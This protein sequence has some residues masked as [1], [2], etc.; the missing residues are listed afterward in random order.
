MGMNLTAFGDGITPETVLNSFIGEV[1][2]W[3]GVL[4]FVEAEGPPGAGM[5]GNHGGHD[6]G[7]DD[8]SSGT[9]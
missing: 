3:P 2:D 5:G 8:G 9:R 4:A 1:L 6:I 7:L